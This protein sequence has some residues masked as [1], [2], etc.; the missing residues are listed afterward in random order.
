MRLVLDNNI[1]FSLMNPDSIA[2]YLF[3]SLKAEFFAPEFI[4]SEFNEYKEVCLFKSG[5]SEHEFELRQ[6][7]VG[8]DIKFFELSKYEDFLEKATALLSDPDDVDFL[9]LA[10]FI[11]AAIWSNDP[12]FKEQSLVRIF[13]TKEL[14]E[15]LLKSE[16]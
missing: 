1:F 10:L 6:K 14:V 12:H 5:L 9:A 13:T 11:N 8:E 7:E 3:F 15:G 2:S 4:K 16:L